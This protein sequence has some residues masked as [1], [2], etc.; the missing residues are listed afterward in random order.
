MANGDA[1]AP[2]AR[3]PEP[4]DLAR[5]C[6]ALNQA[7]ARYVLIGG[8]AM[9]AHGAGRFT[10]DID[11]LVDDA[12]E[13]VARIKGALA[14][15]ADNAAAEVADDDVRTHAVV[16]VVDEVVIDLMGRACGLSY[17]DVAADAETVIVGEVAVI[18]ASP[19]MLIQTKNTYRPQDAIDR[20]FLE[21]LVRE[22]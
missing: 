9:I 11:L 10:R 16:R 14:I 1:G 20:A 7:Q 18:V 21:A 6:R 8:F 3:A 19:R 22:R 2:R 15:L 5:I 17:A 4:E 13:N 12:P